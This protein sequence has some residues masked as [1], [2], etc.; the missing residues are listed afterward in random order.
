MRRTLR[1]A[2]K[3]FALVPVRWLEQYS[4]CFLYLRCHFLRGQPWPFFF[5]S[6]VS[7]TVWWRFAVQLAF[8]VA[9]SSQLA[10]TTCTGGTAQ[11]QPLPAVLSKRFTSSQYHSPDE[12][13]AEQRILHPRQS[14]C[15]IVRVLLH[16]G[17]L[18][19]RPIR[20]TLAYPWDCRNQ[21]RRHVQM[22]A[23][24]VGY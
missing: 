22:V 10:C 21:I 7:T 2:D 17:P 23:F 18:N 12:E 13:V 15:R 3:R 6:F 24:E 4:V 11:K 5:T 20:C 1:A 14:Y 9:D 19:L 16:V 8:V